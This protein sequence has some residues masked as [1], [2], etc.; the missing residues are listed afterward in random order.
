MIPLINRCEEAGAMDMSYTPGMMA[1][2]IAP[3]PQ[4]EETEAGDTL[5]LVPGISMAA[6]NVGQPNVP[7]PNGSLGSLV[8]VSR[9]E[10]GR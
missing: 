3:I 6:A 4:V 2:G 1:P 8:N 9:T 7:V 10:T 5:A